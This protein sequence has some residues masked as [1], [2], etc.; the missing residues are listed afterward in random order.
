MTD[1]KTLP[2]RHQTIITG[3]QVKLYFPNIIPDF[4][5]LFVAGAG[6]YHSQKPANFVEHRD[7]KTKRRKKR[8]NWDRSWKSPTKKKE[9]YICMVGTIRIRLVALWPT[10]RRH[11][12]RELVY[13]CDLQNHAWLDRLLAWHS[14]TGLASR[15]PNT[16]QKSEKA[17]R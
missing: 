1:K 16:K 14:E 6:L 5:P 8:E 12:M 15:W 9:K 2:D 7:P 11:D 10:E 13:A 17:R 4:P 3:M